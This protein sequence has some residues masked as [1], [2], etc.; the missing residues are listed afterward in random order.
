MSQISRT[1]IY[2]LS[3]VLKETGLSA[4]VLRVWERR[5]ELPKPKR[6]PGGHRQYSDFDVATIK[7]LRSR[8][9]EGFSISRAVKLWDELITSGKDPLVEYGQDF[10]QSLNPLVSANNRIEILRTNFINACLDYDTG[11]AEKTLNHAFGL[12]PV[13]TVC[14][15]VIQ[16][17]LNEIGTLW[18]QGKVSVQQEHFA[19]ALILRRIETLIS[20]TPDPT[21]EQR[22]LIGCPSGEWHVF[23][24]L[25]ITLLLR[26]KGLNVI[27]L[28]ANIPLE[29]IEKS[30]EAIRPNLIIMAAQQFVSAAKLR[31]AAILFHRIKFPMAYGGLIFNRIPD[32]R[33]KI[34]AHFLGEDLL[35]A[36]DVV[37]HLLTSTPTILSEK[38]GETE[39]Y[40]KTALAYHHNITLIEASAIEKL[41]ESGLSA[42]YLS[43]VNSFFS[44]ELLAALEF[45]NL[46]LVE[47]DFDWVKKMFSDRNIPPH[48]L[49]IYLNAFKEAINGQL[50]Q[51][52]ALIT[53]WL[54]D[55]LNKHQIS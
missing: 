27:N 33:E 21:R 43:E 1:P 22:I 39:I 19:T 26:R 3:A 45:G 44:A 20:A 28:G 24:I 47:T 46:H 41:R 18:H 10:I 17:S 16:K 13:E 53:E 5:Y 36:P 54:D 6:S 51:D 7:W 52:G 11:K 9:D 4:D 55:Y 30:A 29:Q 35:H 48:T 37:E 8:Q 34:P 32:L 15:D 49:I 42:D 50:G 23:P 25:L 14:F 2:N 40:Q 31:S 38:V 12:F